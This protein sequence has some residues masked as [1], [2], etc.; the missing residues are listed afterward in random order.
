MHHVSLYPRTQ[1][2]EIIAKYLYI[3]IYLYKKYKI[4][5][6]IDLGNEEIHWRTLF[7]LISDRFLNNRRVIIVSMVSMY[8]GFSVNVSLYRK[9][10]KNSVRKHSVRVWEYYKRTFFVLCRQTSVQQQ[11]L[12]LLLFVR[13]RRKYYRAF[14]DRWQRYWRINSSCRPKHKK[15]KCLCR[16]RVTI[17]PRRYNDN[18]RLLYPKRTNQFLKNYFKFNY[19]KKTKKKTKP[20]SYSAKLKFILK[21]IWIRETISKVTNNFY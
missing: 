11:Q 10:K 16:A 14:I 13:W 1:T 5:N 2:E 15:N 8:T 4:K 3:Y 9:K 19:S 12:L 17:S 21:Y 7:R 6:R 20:N 18:T